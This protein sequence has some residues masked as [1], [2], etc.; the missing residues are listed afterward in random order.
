MRITL[1]DEARQF[2]GQFDELVGVPPRDCLIEPDRV[3][4]VIPAG[5]M[6]EAI[7]PDGN[8]VDRAE[9]AIG[10]RIKLVEYADTPTAFVKST[11]AP[12]RVENVTI[13]EQ[14]GTVAF[15]EV[16]EADRAIAIGRDGQTIETARMLVDRQYG[17]SDVQL[18]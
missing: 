1:S 11:L 9:A 6:G 10:R 14:D 15:V 2:M 12:A 7:G 18:V 5:R 17:I 16:C 3:V 8:R 13:S 4:F